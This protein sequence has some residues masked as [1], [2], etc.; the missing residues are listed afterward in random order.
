MTNKRLLD[1]VITAII[2]AAVAAVVARAMRPSTPKES[3]YA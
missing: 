3:A 1:L 2:S